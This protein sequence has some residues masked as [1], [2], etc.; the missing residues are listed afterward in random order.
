M[1][2]AIR[3]L[4]DDVF[5]FQQDSVLAHLPHATVEYLCQATPEFISPDLWPP[6]NPD[7]NPVDYIRFGAVFQEPIRDVDQLK[8][9]GRCVV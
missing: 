1:L 7:L 4:A 6:N 3:H 9:S 5:M 2:P 8:T